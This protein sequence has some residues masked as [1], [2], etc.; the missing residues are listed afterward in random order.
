MFFGKV[1]RTQIDD[2]MDLIV[3]VFSLGIGY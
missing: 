2:G 1:L 3:D